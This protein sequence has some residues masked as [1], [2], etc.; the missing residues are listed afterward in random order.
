MN[1]IQS[2]AQII[3]REQGIS[4]YTAAIDPIYNYYRNSKYSRKN[5]GKTQYDEGNK[6]LRNINSNV[7]D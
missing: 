1:S 7:H 5:T 3:I 4:E 6:C 2:K